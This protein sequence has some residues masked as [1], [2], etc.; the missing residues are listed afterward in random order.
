MNARSKCI[1]QS[2]TLMT[3]ASLVIAIA[4]LMVTTA[5]AAVY[6]V[7]LT[8]GTSF[9]TRYR[10]VDAEWSEDVSMI[11]TDLGNW[12]ALEKSEI[13]DVTSAAEV[14]GFGYQLNTTTLFIGKSPNDLAT[15]DENGES[16]QDY[17]FIDD[18]SSEGQSFTLEQFV[19]PS[20]VGQ[21][22]SGGIPLYGT[23]SGGGGN[24]PIQ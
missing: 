4:L 22:P 17:E 11:L 9:D 18:I 23:G 7:T 8:N 19:S 16:T 2:K 1:G 21:S 5:Q 3:R 10:P 14:K 12:I 20:E 15:V 24:A 6:T 13:A